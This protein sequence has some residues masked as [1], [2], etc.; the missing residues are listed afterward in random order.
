M[1]TNAAMR[2]RTRLGLSAAETLRREGFR[3]LI[4]VVGDEPHLPY[5]RTPLSKAVMTGRI[6]AATASQTRQ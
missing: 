5:D 3:G 2:A 6:P 1:K 4:T